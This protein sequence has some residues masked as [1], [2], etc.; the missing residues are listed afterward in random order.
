MVGE[1]ELAFEAS[2]RDAAMQE[3]LTS[4]SLF[5]PS[6]VSTFCSTVSSTSSGLKPASA[7]EIWKRFSSR[8]S[9]L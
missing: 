4:F 6:S 3:G 2:R 7:I 5:R 8:R 1:R 9:M